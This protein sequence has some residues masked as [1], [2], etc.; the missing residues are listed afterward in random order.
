VFILSAAQS[1][2][3]ENSIEALCLRPEP[4]MH[5]QSLV[6]DM[7]QASNKSINKEK[8]IYPHK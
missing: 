5:A 7:S 4:K 3:S 6:Q 1:T 2:K 8:N